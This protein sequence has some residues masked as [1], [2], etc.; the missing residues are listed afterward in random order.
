MKE[1]EMKFQEIQKMAK[2]MGVNTYRTTKTDLIRT[3]QRQEDNIDCYG[4][5]RVGY[6]F[7]ESCAWRDDC[8]ALNNSHPRGN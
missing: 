6:C 2:G 1:D 8:L 7:E 4:T 5:D 3:I